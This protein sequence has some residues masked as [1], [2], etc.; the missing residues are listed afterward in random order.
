MSKPTIFTNPANPQ[1][2][3]CLAQHGKDDSCRCYICHT[4]MH[5]EFLCCVTVD[6]HKSVLCPNCS[7]TSQRFNLVKLVVDL[8]ARLLPKPH[9]GYPDDCKTARD[10]TMQLILETFTPVLTDLLKP[11]GTVYVI[12]YDVH[13]G[14]K[15]ADFFWG[16]ESRDA[17]LKEIM[18]EQI[19]D[20]KKWWDDSPDKLRQ[21]CIHLE[22]LISHDKIEEA[23]F[24]DQWNDTVK[25]SDDYYYLYD[26]EVPSFALFLVGNP[27]FKAANDA[28]KNGRIQGK[29]NKPVNLN[30]F[31][32]DK[33]MTEW[34]QYEH[35]FIHGKLT[36]KLNL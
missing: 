29:Q 15:D 36:K 3:H 21:A 13:N 27:A 12:H 16:K 33:Q 17:K 8:G 23:F 9:T 25:R 1:C 22:Q 10:E 11:E 18:E 6:G 7:K 14:S 20:V 24:S 34:A 26:S 32:P 19:E 5:P 28:Y 30:P 31:C 2:Q 4:E 35:G